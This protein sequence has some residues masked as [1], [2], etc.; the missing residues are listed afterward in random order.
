MERYLSHL[1]ALE[2]KCNVTLHD[3]LKAVQLVDMVQRLSDEISSY[4]AQLGYEGR[5]IKMQ[6]E[7]MAGGV[8]EQQLLLVK[9]Y[10]HRNEKSAEQVAAHIRQCSMEELK[11]VVVLS[12]V[13][14]HGGS[15]S[16]L[17]ARVSPRGYRILAGLPRIPMQV[18]ENVVGTFDSLQKVLDATV[19]E[20]DDVDGIGEVRAKVIKE[21]LRKAQEQV[22]MEQGESYK[23]GE[24][25]FAQGNDI[26]K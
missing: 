8:A 5:F 9:D 22:V 23:V 16:S 21:G 13:F 6:L 3:A 1:T 19:D 2:F 7:E 18:I 20:L 10:C 11:Q 4:V 24:E 14:G 12:R 25:E 26:E 15:L 17:E